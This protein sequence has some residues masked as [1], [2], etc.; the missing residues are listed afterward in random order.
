[1]CFLFPWCFWSNLLTCNYFPLKKKTNLNIQWPFLPLPPLLSAFPWTPMQSSESPL[2]C[3]CNLPG[4]VGAL[5]SWERGLPGTCSD[6]VLLLVIPSHAESVQSTFSAFLG[7]IITSPRVAELPVGQ[8]ESCGA[9]QPADA[10]VCQH[11]PSMRPLCWRKG[12]AAQASA[13]WCQV[14]TLA[15]PLVHTYCLSNAHVAVLS[16]RG[17]V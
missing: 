14:Q 11:P 1:M 16:G 3:G 4:C 13:L 10:S 8:S 17:G 5:P 6:T 2:P 9:R 15:W 12:S 7:C